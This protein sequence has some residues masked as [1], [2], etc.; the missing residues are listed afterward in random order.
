MDSLRSRLATTGAYDFN[1]AVESNVRFP[2]EIKATQIMNWW[3]SAIINNPPVSTGGGS[4]GA[5]VLDA[6]PYPNTDDVMV[7]TVLDSNGN[8]AYEG[9]F[10]FNDQPGIGLLAAQWLSINESFKTYCRFRPAGA[11]SIYVTLG[12]ANWNWFANVDE[13]GASTWTITSSG[14]TG[15]TFTLTDEFPQW[16]P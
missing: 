5:W 11:N 7:L 13:T 3:W 2:G 15:P 12:R 16:D 9:S 1:L 4:G 10:T 6:D 14:F 8:Q